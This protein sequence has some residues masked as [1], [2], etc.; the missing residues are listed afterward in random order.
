MA[1]RRWNARLGSRGKTSRTSCL[2]V[3]SSVLPYVKKIQAD[4]VVY[5]A[6]D[7]LSLTPEWNR[8]LEEQQ[9]ALLAM[10]DLVL[11]SSDVIAEEL[12][13]ISGKSVEMLPNGADF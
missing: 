1:V 12:T 4:F 3:S 8:E 5:H 13:A 7:M 9:R 6:Y 10:A 11:A 2:F